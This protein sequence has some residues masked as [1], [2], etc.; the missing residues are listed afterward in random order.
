MHQVERHPRVRVVITH[1]TGNVEE[2]SFTA[3]CSDDE[4]LIKL[5]ERCDAEAAGAASRVNGDCRGIPAPEQF[6]VT[7][8]V[9]RLPD[10]P[11]LRPLTER[12]KGRLIATGR[13]AAARNRKRPKRL[14]RMAS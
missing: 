4:L 9:T 5:R 7:P 6:G 12:Q 11:K 10:D 14:R 3:A 13:L 2:W 8:T 1:A